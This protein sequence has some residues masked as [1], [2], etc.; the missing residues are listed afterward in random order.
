MG[1]CY[2]SPPIA[3]CEIVLIHVLQANWNSVNVNA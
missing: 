3:Q 1:V 2:I